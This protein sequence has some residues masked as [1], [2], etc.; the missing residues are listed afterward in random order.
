[1]PTFAIARHRHAA[2]C[3]LASLVLWAASSAGPAAADERS[4][5]LTV[6]STD[7][8]LV[9]DQRTL[10]LPTD[11]GPVS[12]TDVPARIDPTSVHLQ[13][14]HGQ[15]QVLEQN[16]QYD[17]ADP[18]R[19]LQRYLD[20]PVEAAL[21]AGELR[22]G[23]LLSYDGGALVLRGVD[24]G[25]SL[26]ARD[27]IADLR[28]P[29]LPDGLRTRPTLVWR[30]AGA[31]PGP[32]PVSLSYLTGGMSWHAEYVAVTNEEDTRLEL[33][34]WVSLENHSGATFPE[35][36]LQLI[37]GDV[38]RMRPAPLPVR[39]RMV[40]MMEK[41][42]PDGGFAEES[43]FEY[44]LYTLDRATTIADRETK[45]VA[46]FPAASAPVRKVYEFDGQR[47]PR[48]V[49]VLLEAENRAELGLGMP[50]PAGT[51]RVYKKD[52]RG[53]L[54]FVGEDR[55]DHTPRNER[56]RLGVGNAF[57]VVAERRDLAQSRITERVTERSV[58]VSVRNR[59]T[60]A[61][62]VVV[63][64]H[65]AGDWEIRQT[66][67]PAERRD[68]STAAFRVRIEPDAETKLTYTA[69]ERY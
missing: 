54:Q 52:A 53:E 59:K 4:L 1:M 14:L 27:Q 25:I 68:A 37:A 65:L 22:S 42:A 16:F 61:V 20:Q 21:K 49:R 29:Q 45:Q 60:E 58:E 44:H 36:R 8:A 66:S 13:P 10:Q 26:L 56:I 7:L 48:K 3:L 34:A 63:L 30:L 23:N 32:L 69:R 46:L 5:R 2:H 31:N 43:F 47:D 12:L 18:E 40:A 38:Q 11:G 55:L 24:G 35:A 17:L 67:L 50:L 19:I 28:F 33:S 64:E 39:G 51:V 9:S 57:D 62:E 41:A 15:V 6:Y